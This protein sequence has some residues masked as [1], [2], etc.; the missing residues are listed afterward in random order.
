MPASK[1]T[2]MTDLHAALHA[3]ITA[4]LEVAHLATHGGP[5]VWHIGNAV[6]PTGLHNI[7]TFPGA[8][9]VAD[10]VNALDADHIALHGPADAIRRYERDLRVWQRHAICTGCEMRVSGCASGEAWCHWCAHPAPCMEIRDLL[11]VYPEVK[12]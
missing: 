12:R 2:P 3:V 9:S 6:D 7:H 1:H 11:D 4:R 8:Q 10:N 5:G